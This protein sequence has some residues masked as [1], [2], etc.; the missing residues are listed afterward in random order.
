[1]KRFA[2]SISVFVLFALLICTAAFWGAL[3]N[4][5]QSASASQ[6]P[7]Q[8]LPAQ[9]TQRRTNW[10]YARLLVSDGNAAWHAGEVGQI[11]DIVPLEILYQ[12]LGGNRPANLTNLLNVIG[13]DGWELVATDESVWTFKRPTR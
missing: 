7:L 5:G 10:E 11:I 8:Q 9:Q 12:R 6:Q 3:P 2:S 13:R 4:A 1:M